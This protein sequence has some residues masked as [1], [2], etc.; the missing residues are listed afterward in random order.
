M[1]INDE[2]I[3]TQPKDEKKRKLIY[4]PVEGKRDWS[5]DLYGCFPDFC[6]CCRGFCCI[7]CMLSEIASRTG[8]WICFP[9]FVPGGG[10]VLRTR[11]RTMGGIR[12]TACDDCVM[13]CFCGP[14]AIWQM[15]RELDKMGVPKK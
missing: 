13:M 8:E 1:S 10:N 4:S 7:P 12:G 15:E 11:I 5:S 14:C 3:V 2:A 6:S 9:F